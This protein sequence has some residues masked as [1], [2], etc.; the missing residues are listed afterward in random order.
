M[1]NHGPWPS[2][3]IDSTNILYQTIGP[4]VTSTI[5]FVRPTVLKADLNKQ[6]R[7]RFEDYEPP[8]RRRPLIGAKVFDGKYTLIDPT[9]AL[10][11]DSGRV[12]AERDRESIR[13]P[14]SLTLSKIR[15]LKQQALFACVKAKIE[16]STCAL[17]CIYFERICLDCRVDK[18]NRRLSF[19]ACL[20]IAAKINEANSMLAISDGDEENKSDGLLPLV[21]KVKQNKKGVR[22]RSKLCSF[23]QHMIKHPTCS[24]FRYLR[25][26][27]CFLRRSGPLRS[28]NSML[29]VCR[30]VLG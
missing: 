12:I 1:E 18:S 28:S 29:L 9:E 19:A 13:M 10:H 27:W 5:Q 24:P 11:D 30:C 17:A 23:S 20:L 14:P 3:C 16:V 7:E 21:M 22:V 4:I 15:S 6:F 26:C 25:V 8:R 2:Q